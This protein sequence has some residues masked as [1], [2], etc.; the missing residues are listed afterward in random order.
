MFALATFGLAVC[1]SALLP[2]A[3]LSLRRT[4]RR[5]RQSVILDL[6]RVFELEDADGRRE[7]IVP[8]FE[9][10][11]YKYFADPGAPEAGGRAPR[12]ERSTFAFAVC[13]VPLVLLVFAFSV[14]AL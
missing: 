7:Q 13:S 3:I 12:A 9:F 5:H 8:S 1:F 6:Q 14:F 10:V 2:F 11:K 4:V